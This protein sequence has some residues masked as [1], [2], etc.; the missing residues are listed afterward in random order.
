MQINM[1]IQ[2]NRKTVIIIAAILAVAAGVIVWQSGADGRLQAEMD[3]QKQ[4]RQE[5]H[6]QE[7]RNALFSNKM[8]L[9]ERIFNETV[10]PLIAKAEAYQIPGGGIGPW[11][12]EILC[13]T[14]RNSAMELK[15]QAGREYR[16]K[17]QNLSSPSQIDTLA[18]TIGRK[19]ADQ[20]LQWFE[21]KWAEVQKVGPG[22]ASWNL[23][24][25]PIQ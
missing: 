11:D 17:V 1:Q 20:F 7:V 2:F 3:A 18:E 8:P 12:R 22:E 23:K 19:Y 13:R 6:N 14:A 16:S 5:E 10:N 4:Q 21:P 25:A 15:L 9:Y 24:F